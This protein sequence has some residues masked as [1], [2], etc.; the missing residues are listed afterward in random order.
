MMGELSTNYPSSLVILESEKGMDEH[1]DEENGTSANDEN[2]GSSCNGT[3]RDDGVVQ[4][5]VEGPSSDAVDGNKGGIDLLLESE[6]F[7]GTSLPS[8]PFVS[9][10]GNGNGNGNCYIVSGNN[11]SYEGMDVPKLK[12]LCSR[13]RFARCRA[14]FPVSVILYKKTHICR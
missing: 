2:G 11:K 9:N 14:R 12:D 10:V 7:I 13:A 4:V 3:P 5:T 8:T 1:K 6:S